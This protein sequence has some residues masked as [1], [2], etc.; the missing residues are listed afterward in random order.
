MLQAK[1]TGW[2]YL[3]VDALDFNLGKA[4]LFVIFVA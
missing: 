2:Q 1:H 4:L 3:P